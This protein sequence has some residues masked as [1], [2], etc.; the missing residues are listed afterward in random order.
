MKTNIALHRPRGAEQSVLVIPRRRREK[1][2]R[3][4]FQYCS[5]ATGWWL[6]PRLMI[7]SRRKRSGKERKIHTFLEPRVIQLIKAQDLHKP[8]VQGLLLSAPE[9]DYVVP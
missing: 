4:I 3:I 2:T 8:L 1:P 6:S 9:I 5:T 7:R